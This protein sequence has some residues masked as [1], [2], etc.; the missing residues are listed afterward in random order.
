MDYGFV[1]EGNKYEYVS[2][3]PPL[4]PQM[5]L[6][7]KIASK[8]DK[9]KTF[10]KFKIYRHLLNIDLIIYHRLLTKTAQEL[11]TS[12][13]IKISDIKQEEKALQS[14]IAMLKSYIQQQ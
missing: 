10:R 5:Q 4:T 8:L 14:C 12:D 6:L 7:N 9:P 2:L 1:I 11:N 13:L 3:F